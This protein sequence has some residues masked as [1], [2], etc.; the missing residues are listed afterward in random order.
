MSS[1]SSWLFRSNFLLVM[2][3]RDH[4]SPW[5]L[6]LFNPKYKELLNWQL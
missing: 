3:D 1:R 5:Q 4:N 2:D 6:F